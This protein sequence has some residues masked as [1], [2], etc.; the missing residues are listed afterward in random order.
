MR[1]GEKGILIAILVIT[2]GFMV[3]KGWQVSTKEGDDPGI[4]FYSTAPDELASRASV[5][6]RKY[7]CRECHVLW[8]SRAPMAGAVPAPSLDGIGAIRNEEWLYTYFSAENPQSILPSRLKKKYQMPSFA[9]VPEED[10]RSLAA[11]FGS[12]KVEDWYLDEVKK[13]EYE[14]LTGKDYLQ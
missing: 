13:S 3:F 11:Y 8:S 9:F 12:M 2:G 10:R 1:K 4:P 7:K 14:K 5:L 6:Y